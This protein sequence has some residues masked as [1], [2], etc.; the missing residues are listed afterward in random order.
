M[1]SSLYPKPG[2]SKRTTISP[3]R[4]TITPERSTISPE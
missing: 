4:T 2:T 1:R 3:E